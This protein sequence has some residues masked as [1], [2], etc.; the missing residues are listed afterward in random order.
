VVSE[1]FAELVQ[2]SP[3]V[4]E[5][6]VFSQRAGWGEFFALRRKI[7]I[8]MFDAVWDMAGVFRSGLLVSAVKSLEKWGR[9]DARQFSGT[10]YNR[11]IS[12]PMGAGPHHGLD[13]LQPFL[14]A[15]G[16]P[17][18]LYFPM[19][20]KPSGSTYAW[21]EFFSGDP[22]TT[23][24]IFPDNGTKNKAWPYYSELT[25]FIL[26]KIPDSRAVW[27]GMEKTQPKCSMPG[28][29]FL[30]LTGSPL[31][32][33]VALLRQPAT[34]VGNESGPMHLA[35]ASGNPVLALF[36]SSDPRQMGP[37]PV[38][39]AKH[40]AV[41]APDGNWDKLLPAAVMTALAELRQRSM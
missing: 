7:E 25:A 13:I 23:F 1:E 33:M 40:L 30:N 14:R 6:I 17:Q 18:R 21:E 38:D 16:V 15:A 34:F 31:A 3:Y 19:E 37:Y 29:K 8:K 24:V 12:P 22:R 36:G 39:A 26:E 20:L 5:T 28:G 41:P 11:R 35:A 32:E 4:R 2:A 9:P 27:C 10:F